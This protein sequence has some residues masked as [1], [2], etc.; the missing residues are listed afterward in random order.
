MT[1]EIQVTNDLKEQEKVRIFEVKSHQKFLQQKAAYSLPVD[2]RVKK[3]KPFRGFNVFYVDGNLIRQQIDID[4][5]MGGNGYRYLYCPLDEIWIDSVFKKEADYIML[6]EYVELNHMKNGMNYPEAH[7][8]ASIQET[9]LRRG[10]STI[11]D[12]VPQ[13]LRS[14]GKLFAPASVSL[15]E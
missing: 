7:D 12:A 8:L 6:H 14:P 5:V 10:G 9:M 13:P 11:L 3:A 2:P 1:S 4:F 15:G